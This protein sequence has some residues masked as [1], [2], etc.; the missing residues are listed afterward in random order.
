MD[1]SEIT[2]VEVGPRDGLQ[3]E[4]TNIP[5]QLKID[6][7][8]ALSKT[9]LKK[10]EV[11]SF[12]SP[13]WLP[14]MRDHSEVLQGIERKDDICY[15]ALVPNEHGFTDALAAGVDEIAVFTSASETFSMKNTNCSI[16]ESLT[17]IANVVKLAQAHK[18]KVRSY[19][20]C[21]LGCPYEK[22]EVDFNQVAK[23]AQKLIDMGCYQVSLGDTIGVG[24]ANKAKQLIK[25]VNQ[26]IDI[27][28]IAV[29][30]HDTY[31][32]ALTNIYASLELGVTTIDSSVA[33]LGGCPFAPGA[34]G[35]VATED[36]LYL[37]EGLG[38]NPGIKLDALAQ[39]GHLI[40][41]YLGQKPRSKVSIA[42]S[43]A[44]YKNK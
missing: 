28:Q 25:T 36:V 38:L 4:S 40:C 3:N 30:Y 8:N 19:I 42:L 12:V 10:I 37:L 43:G 35:N 21:V 2:I 29:H 26:A 1:K 7:I 34:R 39:A 31:A 22:R 33:G 9:G 41:D 17:R 20:S 15:S 6:F 23:L 44:S 18:I 24:T 13:K 14:Q 16:A 5:T 32:Q 11:T 27:S